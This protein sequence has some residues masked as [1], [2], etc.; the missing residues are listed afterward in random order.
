MK[1]HAQA[2]A[3]AALYRL[4]RVLGDGESLFFV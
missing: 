2:N 1:G 4:R 3:P